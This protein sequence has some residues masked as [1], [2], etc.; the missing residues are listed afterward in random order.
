LQLEAQ[1]GDP[2]FNRLD[3][4]EAQLARLMRGEIAPA[5]AHLDTGLTATPPRRFD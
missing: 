3:D 2:E 5:L 4:Y 1:N